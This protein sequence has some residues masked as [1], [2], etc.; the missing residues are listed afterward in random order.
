MGRGTLPSNDPT[1]QVTRAKGE[2]ARPVEC[3]LHS[4]LLERD[5]QLKVLD[6]V[7]DGLTTT[8][9]KVILIRGE[10]GI[11]KSA[12]ASAF[13]ASQAAAAHVHAGACDDLLIPR[14]LNPFWDMSRTEPSLREQLD[15]GDRSRL[16]DAVL[17][18]MSRPR[19]SILIVEDTQW[20]DAATLDAIRFLGRRIAL[21]NGVLALTYRDS[22]VDLEHPLRGVIGDIPAQSVVR[23]QLDGLSLAG[24]T[25]MVASARLEPGTV[26]RATR[27]NPFL[28]QE[29]VAT[30]EAGL[31]TVRDSVMAQVSRL[32]IGAQEMLKILSVIP[33]PVEVSNLLGIALVDGPRLLECEQRGLLERA[34]GRIAF[35]HE[36]IR[37]AVQS[38]LTVGE[39]LDGYREVLHGL[40]EDT[41]PC[42]LVQCA[43]EVQDVDRLL[44]IAPRSARYNA[45]TG[46]HAEAVLDF[47]VL[48][49]H[50]GR[51]GANELGQWLDEWAREEFLVD[52]VAE[53][54]RLSGLA[55]DHHRGLGDHGAESRSLAASAYYHENAG[56]RAR[57]QTVAREAI[58]VLGPEPAGSDLARALEVN[59]Y[60]QMMAGN[61]SAVL[62]LVERTLRAGGP[63]ID[64]AI[65]I[66]SLN[67]RGI[68]ANIAN[69]PDGRAALDE[70][71]ERAEAAGEWWEE[72]R[73]LL[74]HAWA[75]AEAHDLPIASD[76]AQR[77]IA[78][79]SRHELRTLEGYSKA[80]LSRTLELM[81]RW[82]EASDLARDVLDPG[83][84][85][86]LVARP[87]L[88]VLDVRKGG[89]TGVAELG[90][91]WQMAS[92]AG[93]FQ[94]LAPVAIAIAEHA[95]LTG[96]PDVPVSDL[97]DVMRA[98]LDRGFRWSPGRLALW[99]WELG[100]LSEPPIGIADPYRLVMEGRSSEAAAIWA[101]RGVPYERALALMHGGDPDAFEALEIF[102]TLGATAVAAR[103]R[104]TLR[105]RGV[106]VPRGKGRETRRHAA[107]LTGR[108]AEIL[109]LLAQDLSTNQIADR[110]FISPRTVENHVAAVLDKLDVTSRDAAV[111]RGRAEG[112]LNAAG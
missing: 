111:S 98:G 80:L 78:S 28:V 39:R 81:G 16:M 32:T 3:M 30:P 40:P 107:G 17:D 93:E 64:E 60:L 42:L 15:A 10:A 49:P 108:Q 22:D 50:L 92:A 105:D 45:A 90:H 104:R 66:R 61:V 12:L 63:D 84:L 65:R 101:V 14:A 91:L 6:D 35:R 88:A 56:Q 27:G 5:S 44:A 95:W 19:P 21:T 89:T 94:R 33:E 77:A 74:N 29:M 69:Y 70:A 102:E 36:L 4:M 31:A 75:A 1:P 13:A 37:Q 24:V 41:H 46:S 38:G 54:I 76:Y 99:L 106:A 68:A 97:V 43:Y 83:T 8:G 85:R 25:A 53:A 72:C 23:I 18:L 47:R 48:G 52:D 73:A 71:R 79:A 7:V 2:G 34:G 112:L 109:Q 58:T 57:A 11:G 62:D 103:L 96:R 9:G 26:L 59:A 55:R 20:A 110:L 82:D 67:H 86:M 87:I 100:E 51:I